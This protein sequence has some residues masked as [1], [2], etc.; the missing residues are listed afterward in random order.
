MEL[1]ASAQV[2]VTDAQ[3]IRFP[4]GGRLA[5]HLDQRWGIELAGEW[6][7]ASPRAEQAVLVTLAPGKLREQ[8]RWRATMAALWSPLLGKVS[9]GARVFAFEPYMALGMGL[10]GSAAE[11]RA[12]IGAAVRPEGILS[13][14]LRIGRGRWLLRVEARQALRLRPTDDLDYALSVGLLAGVLLGGSR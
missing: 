7:L 12:H 5:L 4:L 11:T 9:G 2:V 3:Q 13:L 6:V 1:S 10:V 14:G 8:P